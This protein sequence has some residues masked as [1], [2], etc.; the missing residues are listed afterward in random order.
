MAGCECAGLGPALGLVQLVE[1]AV[2]L[3]CGKGWYAGRVDGMF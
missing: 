2:R 3:C 1:F